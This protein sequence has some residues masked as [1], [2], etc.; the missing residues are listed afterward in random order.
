MGLALVNGM[1]ANKATEARKGNAHRGL[2]TCEPLLSPW[3]CAGAGP[4][5]DEGRGEPTL[6][7]P[8]DPQPY[9]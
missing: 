2:L 7:A 9:E 4:L 8:A 6:T 5:V 1:L 3:Q